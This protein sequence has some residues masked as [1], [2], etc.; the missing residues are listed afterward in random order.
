MAHGNGG[1]RHDVSMPY[2]L[3]RCPQLGGD[4]TQPVD[5]RHEIPMVD[6][7]CLPT[8]PVM[9]HFDV[10]DEAVKMGGRNKR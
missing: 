3:K 8:I 4:D 1:K 5:G 2:D 10:P 7:E 6:R 9:P